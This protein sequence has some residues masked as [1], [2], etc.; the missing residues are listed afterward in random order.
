MNA[1]YVIIGDERPHCLVKLY[2]GITVDQY[3][4]VTTRPGPRRV[5]RQYNGI[6]HVHR[7]SDGSTPSDKL[8]V[9]QE[10][11]LIVEPAYHRKKCTIY[12]QKVLN[13]INGE[14]ITKSGHI[15]YTC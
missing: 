11:V 15:L 1:N 9:H 5:K 2:G 14:T 8:Y 10:L 13:Y 7:R 4:P 6:P 3:G 12:P